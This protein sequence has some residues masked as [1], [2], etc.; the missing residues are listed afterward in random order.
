MTLG[1][2][3]FIANPA[4]GKDV[5]RLVARASV[6]N[7]QEKRAILRRAMVGAMTAGAREFW[8][9]PDS[10][11]IG[12]AA[13][14]EFADLVKVTVVD[15]PQTGSAMD[16]VRG[17]RALKQAQCDVVITLGG[18]GTNRAFVQGW[19]DVTLMPISTGTNNVFPRM[20][21]GTVAGAA[22]G[23]LA[24][25]RVDKFTVAR[26]V[27]CV[28]VEIDGETDDLALID[29]V[30][31]N[32]D[33]VGSRALWD[34]GVLQLALLT[35]AEPA[36]VG[37]SSIGGLLHPLRDDED[38]AL[39]VH[40]AV[41]DARKNANSWVMAPIAP[42]TYADVGVSAIERIA[43]NQSIEVVGPCVLAF[44]GERERVLDKGQRARLSVRR[45][46]PWVIDA[47]RALSEAA[48]I[49]LFKR[50]SSKVKSA[51]PK[52]RR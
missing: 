8:I 29:A 20:I 40:L 39:L 48:S 18:D 7:N 38:A 15:G 28:H 31:V 4:S 1:R 6:F 3:G 23:L 2:V 24:A 44:D 35:R 43:L 32:E 5:R 46:G 30:V 22:A 34:A 50:T 19:L 14:E 52:T 42:G 41:G 26:Q 45:D 25:A 11:G 37:I 10:H 49:G 16:T 27:K 21:E 47:T 51:R 13:A 12:A 33:F 9:I 36:A 17:A